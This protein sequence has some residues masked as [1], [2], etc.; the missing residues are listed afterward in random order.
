MFQVF[1]EQLYLKAEIFRETVSSHYYISLTSLE[2]LLLKSPRSLISLSDCFLMF[3]CLSTNYAIIAIHTGE[4]TIINI[5]NMIDK[6]K[7]G[8]R[9]KKGFKLR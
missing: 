1:N 7:N 3:V 4:N 5:F 2:I 9:D 8:N 6:S